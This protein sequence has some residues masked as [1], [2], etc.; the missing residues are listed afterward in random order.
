MWLLSSVCWDWDTVAGIEW[1]G[2]FCGRWQLRG[3]GGTWCPVSTR[4]T[5]CGVSCGVSPARPGSQHKGCVSWWRIGRD[6]TLMMVGSSVT[7]ASDERGMGWGEDDILNFMKINVDQM[8]GP[9]SVTWFI[10]S[11]TL[12][13]WEQYPEICWRVSGFLSRFIILLPS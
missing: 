12:D 9:F 6:L 2:M 11:F 7:R 13:N 10:V 5:G 3:R 8:S 4:V 1:W